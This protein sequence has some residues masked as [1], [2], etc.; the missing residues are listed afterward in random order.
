MSTLNIQPTDEFVHLIKD[1][2]DTYI[3]NGAYASSQ[4]NKSLIDSEADISILSDPKNLINYLEHEV[5]EL[6]NEYARVS[7][8]TYKGYIGL[9]I[10][11]DSYAIT[12]NMYPKDESAKKLMRK[13]AVNWKALWVPEVNGIEI[14]KPL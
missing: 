14:R 3:F 9:K 13:A 5:P 11:N 7:V 2:F 6:L 4:F 10:H 12:V 8:E 1:H